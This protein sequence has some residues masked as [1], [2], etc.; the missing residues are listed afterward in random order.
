MTIERLFAVCTTNYEQKLIIYLLLIFNRISWE[1]NAIN[2]ATRAARVQSM[3][4]IENFIAFLSQL[5][6]DFAKLKGIVNRLLLTSR[7]DIVKST[8]S[9]CE[10]CRKTERD[11]DWWKNRNIQ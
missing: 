2:D 8:T 9:V 1:K 4:Q 11:G 6:N 10:H 3:E 7:D 5:D